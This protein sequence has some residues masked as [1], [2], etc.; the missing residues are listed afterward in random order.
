[1]GAMCAAILNAN[2]DRIIPEIYLLALCKLHQT[3]TFAFLA[4]GEDILPTFVGVLTCFEFQ[5]HRR[6]DQL[7]FLAEVIEQ[8]TP[9]GAGYGFRLIAMDN[10]QRRILAAL[11]CVA[12][13]DT[14]PPDQGGLMNH[15]RFFQETGQLRGRTLN[16]C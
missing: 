14:P 12:Q 13:L 16:E 6:S 5:P 8:I 2:P 7:E 4:I 3:L 9:V 11:M 10:D 1:M 15:Y